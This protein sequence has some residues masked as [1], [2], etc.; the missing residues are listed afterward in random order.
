M[1]TATGLWVLHYDWDL[2][3]SYHRTPIYFNFDSTFGYLAG[4][5]DGTWTQVEG[6]IIWRFKKLPNEEN[7]SI[8]TG[9]VNG[10]SMLGI[11]FSADGKKGRW[12]AVK[13]GTKV[14]AL[15]ENENLPYLVEKESEP[16]LDPT[17][18]KV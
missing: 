5:N 15:K 10:N 14:Y 3:G 4:A 6:M 13:K 12:Y 7:N 17:G 16:K 11:M 8:Y 18:R 1:L 9:N 2:S